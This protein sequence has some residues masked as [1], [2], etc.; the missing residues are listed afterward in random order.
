MDKHTGKK[1]SKNKSGAKNYTDNRE[2]YAK[3][4]E[5]GKAGK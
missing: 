3:D 1:S 5:F 4:N 2:E